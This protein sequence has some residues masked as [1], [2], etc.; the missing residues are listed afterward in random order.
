MAAPPAT[1]PPPPPLT[2]TPA[3]SQALKETRSILQQR[4]AIQLLITPALSSDGTVCTIVPAIRNAHAAFP[5]VIGKTWRH[6]LKRYFINGLHPHTR[7]YVLV[8]NP[9]SFEETE[10]QARAWEAA[11]RIVYGTDS[12]LASSQKPASAVHVIGASASASSELQQ[13]KDAQQHLIAAVNRIEHQSY[14]GRRGSNRG[15]FTQNQ[16]WRQATSNP[17]SGRR[18]TAGG[19]PICDY[20]TKPDPMKMGCR[21]HQSDSQWSVS[22]ICRDPTPRFNT[23]QHTSQYPGMI[24]RIAESR[25]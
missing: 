14:H 22:F 20:C 13:L 16:G 10:A 19:I 9:P 23:Q 18:Y 7:H 8:A 3:A 2:V 21:K 12:S 25:K 17:D 15:R 6:V 24:L 4:G 1:D 5:A 11:D